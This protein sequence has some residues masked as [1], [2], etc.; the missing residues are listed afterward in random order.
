MANLQELRFYILE[1]GEI[2]GKI[3]TE[4]RLLDRLLILDMDF[5]ALTGQIPEELLS[6]DSLQQLDLND[7][8]LTGSI[9]TKIGDMT[10]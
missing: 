10:T 2:S 9:S 1:Q 3:P 5:N 7:N 4:Y 6:M 8:E